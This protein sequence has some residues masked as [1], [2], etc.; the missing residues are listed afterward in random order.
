ML[1]ILILTKNLVVERR[2]QENLQYLNYE[3]FCSVKIFNRLK[4]IEAAKT[5]IH[6]FQL[7]ILSDTISDS[8]V[9]QLLP[10]LILTNQI[11][12]RK[13]TCEPSN[14]QKTMD[15]I[16]DW[17]IVKQHRFAGSI[18][19]KKFKKIKQSCHCR[20][21]YPSSLYPK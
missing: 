4:K 1:P 3:V 17:R 18:K 15:N 5:A 11:I 21:P 14:S 8:E 9:I 6:S 12:F 10:K 16:R 13:I 20:T 7:L 2:L 19:T